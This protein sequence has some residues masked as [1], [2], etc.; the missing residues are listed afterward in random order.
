MGIAMMMQQA[1]QMSGAAQNINRQLNYVN[2]QNEMRKA[3]AEGNFL[4]NCVLN[5][6]NN[7]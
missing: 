2:L 4:N 1:A 5:K 3:K 7:F 6:K